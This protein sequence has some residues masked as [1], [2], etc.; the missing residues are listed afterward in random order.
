MLMILLACRTQVSPP[1]ANEAE[2][3]RDVEG[4]ARPEAAWIEERTRQAEARLRRTEAG[5]VVWSAIEAAGGLDAWFGASPL[6]F[7]FDYRP[8]NGKPRRDTRQVVDLWRSRAVHTLAADPN[9]RFGWDGEHAW[10][11]VPEGSSLPINPRFWS[12]TPYYFVGIPFVLADSGV[13]LELDEPATFEGQASTLVRVSFA[14]GT[15]DADDDAYVVYIANETKRVIALRYIVSYPGFFE[16]GQHSPWKIMAYDGAQTVQ[17]LRLPRQYRTFSWEDGPGEQV[18]EITL[19][20]VQAQPALS[21]SAF[22]MPS[23]ATVQ[24]GY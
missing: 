11:Q 18:T 24:D 20:E 7:H 6:A 13:Q 2:A 17:D 16:E 3:T 23:G 14:D 4:L 1:A 12:L 19:N 10:Q 9:V 8:L 5:T 21:R 22:G 15:G